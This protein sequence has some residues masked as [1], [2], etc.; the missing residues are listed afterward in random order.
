MKNFHSG[1]CWRPTDASWVLGACPL[2]VVSVSL[3]LR[4]ERNWR[5][6][7]TGKGGLTLPSAQAGAWAGRG[8]TEQAGEMAKLSRAQLHAGY[9]APAWRFRLTMWI[10]QRFFFYLCTF[11]VLSL[12]YMT[13]AR[14]HSSKNCAWRTARWICMYHR[15]SQDGEQLCKGCCLPGNSLVWTELLGFCPHGIYVLIWVFNFIFTL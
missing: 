5:G 8:L 12:T 7:G 14:T 1:L 15:A 11:C 2:R 3:A 4:W 9:S 10:L 13:S 6:E